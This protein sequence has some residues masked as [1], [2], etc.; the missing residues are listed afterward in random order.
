MGSSARLAGRRDLA[1]VIKSDQMF[2]WLRAMNSLRQ[3][4]KA[5]KGTLCLG[6]VRGK[7][8]LKVDSQ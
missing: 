3:K 6:G 8:V 2:G 7:T 1:G 4:S 5:G